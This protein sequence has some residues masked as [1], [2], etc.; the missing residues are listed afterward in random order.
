L[1]VKPLQEPDHLKIPVGSHSTPISI[2]TKGGFL[3]LCIFF[4]FTVMIFLKALRSTWLLDRGHGSRQSRARLTTT[5]QIVVLTLFWL[6]TKDI[7]APAYGCF[8]A[9]FSIGLF[10]GFVDNIEEISSKM[11][12]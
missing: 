9:F 4:L 2:F 12:R 3:S 6:T 11:N 7:D 1:G 5:L 10:A 8:M